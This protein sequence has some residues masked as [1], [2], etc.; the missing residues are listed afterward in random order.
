MESIEGDKENIAIETEP[1]AALANSQEKQ[2]AFE[3]QAFGEK[4]ADTNAK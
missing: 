2:S 4:Q 1:T 3:K